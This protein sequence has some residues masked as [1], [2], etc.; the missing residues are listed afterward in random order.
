MARRSIFEAISFV[1]SVKENSTHACVDG[2][3]YQVSVDLVN[4]GIVS[5]GFC[6]VAG[7]MASGE[8]ALRTRRDVPQ[9]KLHVTEGLRTL[10]PRYDAALALVRAANVRE[11][12]K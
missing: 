1:Q 12:R 9:A 3:R 2:E 4:S 11:N 10:S 6:R 5:P 8:L 7:A